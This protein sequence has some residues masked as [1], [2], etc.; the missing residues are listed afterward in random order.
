[1]RE[2]SEKAKKVLSA[3]YETPV[4]IESIL[5]DKDFRVNVKRAEFLS[6]AAPLLD[7]VLDPLV[8]LVKE[9]ELNPVRLVGLQLSGFLEL[10]PA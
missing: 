3:N 8:S 10:C 2:A 1:M 7:R 4:Y 5:N 6:L 9:F